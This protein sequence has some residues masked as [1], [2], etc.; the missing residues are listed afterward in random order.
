MRESRERESTA[1][2]HVSAWTSLDNANSITVSLNAAAAVG[3][4]IHTADG[5]IN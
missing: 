3:D 5:V 2:G 1:D 4:A